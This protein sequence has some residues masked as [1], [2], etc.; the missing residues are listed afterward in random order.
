MDSLLF[1][2]KQEPFK[3][4]IC[5]EDFSLP[6]KVKNTF[7]ERAKKFQNLDAVLD[8]NE[9]AA[10]ANVYRDYVFKNIDNSVFDK[11]FKLK[12]FSLIPLKMYLAPVSPI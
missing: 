11:R 2:R 12:K 9:S 4:F 5:R 7:D 10:R 1:G 6:E 3:T 8:A